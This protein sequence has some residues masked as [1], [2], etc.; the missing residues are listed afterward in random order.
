MV[1]VDSKRLLRSTSCISVRRS[2]SSKAMRTTA[3]WLLVASCTVATALGG[4]PPVPQAANY[5]TGLQL[6]GINLS[7]AEF[8]PYASLVPVAADILQFGIAGMNMARI[9]F[10][11][12]VAQPLAGGPLNVKYI[13]Q[14]NELA[15]ALLAK[16]YWPLF[17][18][19]N[20]MRYNHSIVDEKAMTDIWHRLT[21][22]APN[23]PNSTFFALASTYTGA[24]PN[25]GGWTKPSVMFDVMNEPNSMAS[26]T[27]VQ[28]LNAAIAAIR[29]N[30]L[31]NPVF[32]EGNNWSGLHSW[33]Q[34]IAPNPPDAVSMLGIVDPH[35]NTVINVHQYLDPDGSGTHSDCVDP[36]T[37]PAALNWT[38]FTGW[39]QENQLQAYLSEF[40]AADNSVCRAGISALLSLVESAAWTKEL[41]WGFVG[42]SAWSAG[43][44]WGSKYILGLNP[45]D[46]AAAM[47]VPTYAPHLDPQCDGFLLGFNNT[48]PEIT[49]GFSI[50][51][52]NPDWSVK[53]T[54]TSASPNT[55]PRLVCVPS[56]IG[57]ECGIAIYD[58]KGAQTAC[59][60]VVTP[61]A[62][63]VD[64]SLCK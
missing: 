15:G 47:M 48:P 1:E 23:E 8:G 21:A 46:Q 41:G 39:L 55:A 58:E 11:W 64:L 22:P 9:P 26:A 42:F 36:D 62:N 32:V 49:T 2:L 53:A 17:D 18:L 50:Q 33:M 20:Y 44:A 37:L 3:G 13:A 4:D 10:K 24:G 31:N 29:A 63:L 6:R 40:G 34:A 25:S 61:Q 14:L 16:G 60:Q 51:A 52:H 19:H 12:E 38:A 54:L 45:G 27:A 57:G 5:S 43:H 7:G 59:P 35:N 28:N 56:A 30:G